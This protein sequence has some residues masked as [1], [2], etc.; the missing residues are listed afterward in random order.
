LTAEVIAPLLPRLVA[1]TC[2]RLVLAGIL[3]TQIEAVVRGLA[4]LGIDEVEITRDGE[5]V[6]IVV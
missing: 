3:E 6:A 5:W 4:Q 2:G 1:L